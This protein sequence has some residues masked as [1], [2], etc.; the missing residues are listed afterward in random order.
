MTLDEVRR[1][2]QEAARGPEGGRQPLEH[3]RRA[4]EDVL[5]RPAERAA[6]EHDERRDRLNG[7]SVRIARTALA[8]VARVKSALCSTTTQRYARPNAR[9]V[10]AERV[11]DRR[12]RARSR[13]PWPRAGR[14]GARSVLVSTAFV[15]QA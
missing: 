12:A 4:P 6:R 2:D 11:R 7:A 9:P 3:G 8:T 5:R 15:I 1:G 13:R 14:A 10:L